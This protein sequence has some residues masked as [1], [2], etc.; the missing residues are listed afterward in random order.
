MKPRFRRLV[1]APTL[2]LP[3]PI[4][5]RPSAAPRLMRVRVWRW[6]VR[7]RAAPASIWSAAERAAIAREAGRVG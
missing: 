6:V 4:L 2:L 5:G 7:G 1:A 3:R